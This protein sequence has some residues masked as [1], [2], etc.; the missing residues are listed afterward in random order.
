MALPLRAGNGSRGTD[1]NII[2]L[3]LFLLE[4]Q[5]NHLSA[6]LGQETY[7][8]LSPPTKNKSRNKTRQ[9]Q[10]SPV[11]TCA[12]PDHAMSGNST[13]WFQSEAQNTKSVN[14]CPLLPILWETNFY[15]SE[16]LPTEIG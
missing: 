1:Y 5:E 12:C 11:G 10:P 9:K 13:T 4:Q 8:W 3:S 14:L 16:L 7:Y 2:Y 6:R 15:Q